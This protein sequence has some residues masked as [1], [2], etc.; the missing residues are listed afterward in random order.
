LSVYEAEREKAK[1]DTSCAT[2]LAASRI[3]HFLHHDTP[4]NA[5]VKKSG[6]RA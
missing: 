4:R 6:S 3:G 1:A 5:E 2:H